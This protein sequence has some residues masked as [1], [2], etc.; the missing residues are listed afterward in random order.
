MCIF[1]HV[2]DLGNVF[3][4]EKGEVKTKIVDH[5]VSLFGPY[6]VYGRAFV[7]SDCCVVTIASVFVVRRVI[8]NVIDNDEIIT[9]LLLLGKPKGNNTQYHNQSV[10]RVTNYKSRKS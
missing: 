6:T 10:E 1:R 9:V 4:D 8:N 2:G 3:S 7:V 5:L